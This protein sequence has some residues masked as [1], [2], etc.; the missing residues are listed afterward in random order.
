MGEYHRSRQ[1]GRF[2]LSRV[3]G[4][5]QRTS[6]CACR[7]EDAVGRRGLAGPSVI[8]A[9]FRARLSAY[10]RKPDASQR[11]AHSVPP[12]DLARGSVA[13]G[14]TANDDELAREDGRREA[15]SE[16]L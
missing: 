15:G 4:D 7:C 1:A 5:S 12:V 3:A 8:R 6:E 14:S 9:I 11:R 10:N 16:V 2:S 13:E